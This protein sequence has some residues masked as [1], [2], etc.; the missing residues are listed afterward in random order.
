MGLCHS[1]LHFSIGDTQVPFS[2]FFLMH[3]VSFKDI[4]SLKPKF[5]KQRWVA[6]QKRGVAIKKQFAPVLSSNFLMDGFRSVP[7]KGKFDV[8]DKKIMDLEDMS[9]Y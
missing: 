4:K 2:L 6:L 9:F 5:A 3:N 1:T 8:C 7:Y